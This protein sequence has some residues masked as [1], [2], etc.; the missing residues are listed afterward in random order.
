MKAR[1]LGLVMLLV[2]WMLF[3]ATITYAG[4]TL[5]VRDCRSSS[6]GVCY[7]WE[8]QQTGTETQYIFLGIKCICPKR[9]D[10][11]PDTMVGKLQDDSEEICFYINPNE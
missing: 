7:W 6:P 8:C 5:G 1:S 4:C 10:L 9:S 2:F 3:M 11:A